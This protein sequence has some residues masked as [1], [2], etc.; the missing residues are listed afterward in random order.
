MGFRAYT[1][2]QPVDNMGTVT[3]AEY[4]GGNP[5]ERVRDR[6]GR[7]FDE[8]RTELESES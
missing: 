4:Y 5:P 3:R 2:I 8:I 1:P 7:I 6:I